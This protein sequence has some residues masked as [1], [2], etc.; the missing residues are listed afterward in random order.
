MGNVI[1]QIIVEKRAG[2]I[3]KE[4]NEDG[5]VVLLPILTCF[6][7]GLS[8]SPRGVLRDWPRP[9]FGRPNPTQVWGVPDESTEASRGAADSNPVLNSEFVD[10]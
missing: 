9:G 8:D 5:G 4:R 2:K 7:S 10:F 1:K 6:K 3:H